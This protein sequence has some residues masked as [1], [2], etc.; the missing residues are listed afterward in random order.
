MCSGEQRIP[1]TEYD[2]C[3]SGTVVVRLL[4]KEK[5]AGSIPVSRLFFLPAEMPY[6]GVSAFFI[7]HS[8]HERHILVTG[9]VKEDGCQQ[10]E[11]EPG[12][13]IGKH[14]KKTSV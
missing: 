3:A 7:I 2:K 1:G 13:G 10:G 6:K 12:E 9:P 4:A 11:G 14:K 5:I 8:F